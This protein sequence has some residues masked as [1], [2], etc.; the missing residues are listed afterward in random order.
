MKTKAIASK[1]KAAKKAKKSVWEKLAG[2]NKLEK[3]TYKQF[4]TKENGYTYISKHT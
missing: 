2:V 4:A 3:E 1:S